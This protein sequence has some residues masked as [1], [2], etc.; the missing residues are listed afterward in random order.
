MTVMTIRQHT[1]PTPYMVGPVHFYSAEHE[2]GLVLFDTGPPTPEGEAALR[3]EVD[4]GR[5]RYALITHCHVDHYGLV[6]LLLK[7]SAAE[8]LIPRS[9]ALKLRHHEERLA[10]ISE[11]LAGYGFDRAFREQLQESFERNRIFPEAPERFSIVEESDLPARLGI[12]FVSCPGHSQSDLVYLHGDSAISGDVLL[13]G[14]FQAPLLDLDLE[15]FQGRFNNY[16]AYC[17]SLADLGRLWGYRI[18]PGHREYLDGVDATILWYVRTL[19]QRAALVLP[20][21]HLPVSEIAAQLFRGRITDPF[22][23]YLKVSEIVCMLDLIAQP[24]LLADALAGIG[25]LEPVADCF[26]PLHRG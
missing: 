17:R 19:L 6:N 2:D 24:D 22:L 10:R 16:R 3:G 4:L 21:R 7:E 1:V 25:L 23:I 13:R 5:L 11:L 18:L 15:T 12:R 14:I 9:D 20:L 26:A 8:V